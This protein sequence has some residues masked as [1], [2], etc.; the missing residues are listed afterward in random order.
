MLLCCNKRIVLVFG[1]FVFLILFGVSVVGHTGGATL[2][3]LAYFL[4]GT[5]FALANTPALPQ[6]TVA[7]AVATGTHG[8]SGVDA[9]TGRLKS[10][11][12]SNR[13]SAREHIDGV[14]SDPNIALSGRQPAT[15]YLC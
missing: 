11:H 9:A 10:P 3:E 6:F 1:L 14:H 15:F 8:S 12:H 5:G 13:E 2:A 7:G 4:Q